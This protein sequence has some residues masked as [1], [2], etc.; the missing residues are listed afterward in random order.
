MC[1]ATTVHYVVVEHGRK[2]KSIMVAYVICV[3]P[4]QCPLREVTCCR[5]Q[6]RHHLQAYH[7]FRPRVGA[8]RLSTLQQIAFTSCIF[9]QFATGKAVLL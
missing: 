3:K 9:Q 1:D 2:I 5:V 8:A 4:P 7:I 6:V